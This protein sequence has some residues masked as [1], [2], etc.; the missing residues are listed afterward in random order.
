MTP[1]QRRRQEGRTRRRNHDEQ[2]EMNLM[3]QLTARSSLVF[4]A[5]LLCSSVHAGELAIS[6]G[7]SLAR[8]LALQKGKTVTVQLSSGQEL[9]GRVKNVTEDLAQ[10]TELSGKEFFDAVIDIDA[11]AA[12]V[13]RTR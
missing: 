2:Q 10:L 5:T 8:V 7:D 3:K 13:V 6:G 9:T 1:S 11:I 12:V 4:L